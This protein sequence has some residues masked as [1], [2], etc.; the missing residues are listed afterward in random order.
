VYTATVAATDK[1]AD[2]AILKVS[3][4]PFVTPP[5]IHRM[6]NGEPEIKLAS[7]DLRTGLPNPGDLALLA[8]YPL[9]RPDLLTQRG[10]VAAVALV[11]DFQGAEA[12]KGVRII[13]SLVSNPANSGGP[14]FDSDGEVLGLLQG[15]FPSPVIE[16]Q[17]QALYLRPK[18]DAN[19]NFVLDANRRPQ[20]EIAPMYQNSG[21]S[22][23]VPA[24]FVQNALDQAQ[25][26]AT[27]AQTKGFVVIQ[28]V[29]VINTPPDVGPKVASSLS[30]AELK[31]QVASFLVTFRSF[32][33][34][35]EG[36]QLQLGES[37]G[38]ALPDTTREDREAASARLGEEFIALQKDM[39][40]Q[41][42]ERFKAEAK[43]LRDDFWARLPITARDTRSVRLYDYGLDLVDLRHLADD[44]GRLSKMLPE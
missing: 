28:G 22:V 30:P 8:G 21:I 4:N 19:G 9:G 7:A 1:K 18:R 16:A 40:Q 27:A 12:S 42:H 2:V 31:Q 37:L 14:V 15:N 20:S 43:R 5:A 39:R 6:I 13:L 33:S 26:K 34:Q 11:D 36:L 41:Y 25:G 44:L 29:E 35:Q 23:V 32:L 24:R 17:R 10:T 38:R 3:P